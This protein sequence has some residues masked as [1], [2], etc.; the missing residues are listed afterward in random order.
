MLSTFATEFNFNQPFSNTCNQEI[1]KYDNFTRACHC[2]KIGGAI[3]NHNHGQHI[4][5][6]SKNI[7]LSKIRRRIRTNN[8][9]LIRPDIPKLMR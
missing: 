2:H 4:Y 6:I 7:A 3:S 1:F 5:Y 9:R 8:L